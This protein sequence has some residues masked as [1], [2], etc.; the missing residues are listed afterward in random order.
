MLFDA[1]FDRRQDCA[2]STP[3]SARQE[4][5]SIR[6]LPEHVE[7]AGAG[8]DRRLRQVLVEPILE[9]ALIIELLK[10]ANRGDHSVPVGPGWFEIGGVGGE[11]CRYDQR[12]LCE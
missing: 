3:V 10:G 9:L 12:A 7:D 11:P 5:D 2:S 8:R 4:S 1:D 6:S